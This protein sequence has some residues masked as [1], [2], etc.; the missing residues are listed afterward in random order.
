MS[1]VRITESHADFHNGHRS[2]RKHTEDV[3]W[4]RTF[5]RFGWLLQVIDCS[6]GR[7]QRICGVGHP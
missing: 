2:Y 1:G 3:R 6:I 5:V 4:L 7:L